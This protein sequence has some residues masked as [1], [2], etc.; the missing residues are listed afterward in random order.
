MIDSVV[1]VASFFLL[2]AVLLLNLKVPRFP[3][4]GK[5][6]FFGIVVVSILGSSCSGGKSIGRAIL[7]NRCNLM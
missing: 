2:V 7:I 1:D 6:F 3:N 5:T 4:N